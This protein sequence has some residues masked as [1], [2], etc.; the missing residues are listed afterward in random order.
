MNAFTGDHVAFT[1]NYALHPS[2]AGPRGLL[3]VL[4]RSIEANAGGVP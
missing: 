1:G 2:V 4:V 3:Q